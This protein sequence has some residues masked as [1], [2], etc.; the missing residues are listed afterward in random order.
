MS[1]LA[2]R[3]HRPPYERAGEYRRPSRRATPLTE[4]E[5][6]AARAAATVPPSRWFEDGLQ[7]LPA[8][9]VPGTRLSREEA[10]AKPGQLC[11]PPRPATPAAPPAVLAPVAADPTSVPTVPRAESTVRKPALSDLASQTLARYRAR[12]GL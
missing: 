6:A 7:A 9:E 2:A 8:L 3:L 11:T 4:R 5:R 12:Y 10:L 1:A